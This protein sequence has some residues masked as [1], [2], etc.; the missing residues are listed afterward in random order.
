MMNITIQ[1][2]IYCLY[3]YSIREFCPRKKN[4]LYL[5]PQYPFVSDPFSSITS[6]EPCIAFRVELPDGNYSLVPETEEGGAEADLQYVEVIEDTKGTQANP[7]DEGK[8]R[9]N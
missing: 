9:C 4:Y 3:P 2:K 6:P 1:H 7:V 8:P 5:Y